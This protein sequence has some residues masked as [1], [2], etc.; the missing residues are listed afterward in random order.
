VRFGSEEFDR[1]LGLIRLSNLKLQGTKKELQRKN[2]SGF[3]VKEEDLF[4]GSG[5]HRGDMFRAFSHLG[6]SFCTGPV[7]AS[8]PKSKPPD[9]AELAKNH[10]ID[11]VD[12]D[13]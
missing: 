3:V 6:T 8:G 12:S 11:G 7:I 4:K 2:N 9:L 13:G 5:L 10:T 1:T